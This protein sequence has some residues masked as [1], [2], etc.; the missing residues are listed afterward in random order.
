MQYENQKKKEA[1]AMKYWEEKKIEE[2]VRDGGREERRGREGERER[3]GEK[4]GEGGRE[5]GRGRER[6]RGREREG[7]RKVKKIFTRPNRGRILLQFS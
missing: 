1:M 6:R 4:E 2:Q 3:E 7:G 5:R